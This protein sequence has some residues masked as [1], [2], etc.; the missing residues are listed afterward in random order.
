MKIPT[1]F[2]TFEPFFDAYG[3][4]IIIPVL[5]WLALGMMI[6]ALI[7]VGVY[8]Y[9]RRRDD[10]KARERIRS[11]YREYAKSIGREP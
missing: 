6:V 3:K 1:P 4:D 10:R 7:L 11:K 8:E 2:E 5:M 9:Q